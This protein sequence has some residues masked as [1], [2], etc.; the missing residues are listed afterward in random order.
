LQ[1]SDR[2]SVLRSGRMVGRADP[3][4]AGRED[5]ARLMVGRDVKLVP[6]K[7]PATPGD[8]LL[9][10]DRIDVRNDRGV[11]SM[12]EFSMQARAG[13]ILGIAGV[14]GNGQRILAEAIAGLRRVE[15]GAIRIA[16]KN[17][18][19]ASARTIRGTGFAY[20]PE[21][22]MRDGA[23]ADFTVAENLTLVDHREEAYARRGFLRLRA[24][25]EHARRLVTEYGVKTPSNGTLAA[26]LSGGNIQKMILAR[27][28]STDP[29]VILAAQPTR[30]VDVGSAEYI[31]KRLI[32]RRDAGAAIVVIS[33]DLDEVIGLADRIL[34]LYEAKVAGVVD[35][36]D[37]D[38]TQIGLLMA[39]SG[40][41]TSPAGGPPG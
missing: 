38:R 13:E 39:G 26:G 31:H 7:D 24:I 8:V 15:G 12:Q 10:V 22:R 32:E 4:T 21:E 27:E 18:T 16:G 36:A 11:L 35:A 40:R 6:D 3:R 2:I 33:E 5:L 1:I 28:L 34:V 17:V 30:G 14:S 37:A 29:L 19:N 25:D 41:E 20:V 23:V 9:D